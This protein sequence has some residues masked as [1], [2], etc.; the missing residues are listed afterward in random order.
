MYLE[1]VTSHVA[2]STTLRWVL[3]SIGVL[4]SGVFAACDDDDELQ[5]FTDAQIGSEI[6]VVAGE[7]FEIRLESNP[8]TGYGWELSAMTT[9]DLVELERSTHLAADTD[10]VG[11]AGTDVFVFAA[12]R[13]AGILRLEYIRSFDDPVIPE[14]V[15]EFVI[16]IDGAAWPP[17]AGTTPS[18]NTAVASG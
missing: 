15:A 6:E 11:V 18:T 10:L 5:V 13:G 3:A 14:R 7:Q 4:L 17:S 8:S 9:P 2:K 12:G 1:V 16:R